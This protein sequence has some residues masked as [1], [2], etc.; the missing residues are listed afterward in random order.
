[1]KPVCKPE[2]R[3]NY[4]ITVQDVPYRT[5]ADRTLRALIYR[6]QG[7]GP[8]PALICIHGGAWISGDRGA[9]QGIAEVIAA[10]GVVVVAIDFRMAPHD[11]YPSSLQDINYA[12][13]WVKHHAA[14]LAISPD[15]V[16]GL[17]VSSGGH[18]ILLAAMKP[19]DRRYAAI[20]FDASVDAE[21]DFVITYSGVLDP[22]D[23]YEM[24]QQIGD[25]D[26]AMCHEAYFGNAA[27]MNEA[28]PSCI[29]ERG[30]QVAL[31][32]AL[33][34]QGGEDP[35]VPA[36]TAERTAKLYRQAGGEAAAHVYSGMGHAL[37]E[38][39][40]AAISD[41]L[42][43]TLQLIRTCCDTAAASKL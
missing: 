32:P 29:L 37:G 39:N 40:S 34:F 13:R 2:M 11:P 4:G 16:G 27:V 12:I 41:A 23:R 30:E 26:I 8:F 20:A 18:L 3:P 14:E 28:S 25:R 17:G 35:R 22:L 7:D 10:C 38:W 5:T 19:Y 24:A 42:M 9:T 15:V 33:F 31:P 1:M 43:R 6:P 36:G 21:L